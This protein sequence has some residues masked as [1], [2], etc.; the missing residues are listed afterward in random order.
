[1]FA[2]REA[3]IA[4]LAAAWERTPS[5]VLVV[6]EAGI[7]KSRLVA[8]FGRGLPVVEGGADPGCPPYGVLVPVLRRLAREH[9]TPFGPGELATLLPELGGAHGRPLRGGRG[10]SRR[11]SCWSSGQGRW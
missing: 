8:E 7:G 2:G 6:G 5:A 3:E 1:M 10:C 11:C 4:A 9:G